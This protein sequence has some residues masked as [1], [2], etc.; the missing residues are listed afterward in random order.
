MGRIKDW[1]V[2]VGLAVFCEMLGVKYMNGNEMLLVR[3]RK[4]IVRIVE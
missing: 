1:E 2:M 4:E 3:I